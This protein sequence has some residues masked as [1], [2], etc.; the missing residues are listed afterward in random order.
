[1]FGL[2]A[3]GLLGGGVVGLASLGLKLGIAWVQVYY[4]RLNIMSHSP[5]NPWDGLK[6]FFV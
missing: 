1:M 6:V 3:P 2:K 5:C 4:G